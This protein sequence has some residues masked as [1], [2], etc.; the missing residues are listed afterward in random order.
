LRRPLLSPCSTPH[1]RRHE[2]GNGAP[3][4][5]GPSRQPPQP[6]DSLHFLRSTCARRN[7]APRR[8]LASVKVQR[9]S[10]RRQTARRVSAGMWRPRCASGSRASRGLVLPNEGPCCGFIRSDAG[11][12]CISVTRSGADPF[13]S[14]ASIRSGSSASSS[15]VTRSGADVRESVA[16]SGRS[17]T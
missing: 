5:V 8:P 3:S 17:G 9:P 11:P 7:P 13:E 10:S 12:S 6:A 2:D 1:G 15:R 16:R 4:E 14:A